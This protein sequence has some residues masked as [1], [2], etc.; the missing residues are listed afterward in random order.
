VLAVRDGTA[1][2]AH[3]ARLRRE[4]EG[5]HLGLDRERPC[6]GRASIDRRPGAHR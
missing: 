1:E 5:R 3:G 4:A 2:I 6:R